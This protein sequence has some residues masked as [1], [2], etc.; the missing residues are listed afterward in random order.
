MAVTAREVIMVFRGQNYLSSTIRQVGRSVGGLSQGQQLAAQR[1]QLQ[2]TRQRMLLFRNAAQAELQSVQ[3]GA[4]RIG[5][6][7][8]IAEQ[9]VAQ[10]RADATLLRNQ[11]QLG[12]ATRAVNSGRPLRG[13]NMVETI[14]QQ[15]A[16]QIQVAAATAAIENQQIAVNKL[17]ADEIRLGEREAQ[18]Q[19]TVLNRTRGIGIY[20]DKLRNLRQ[21]MLQLP[22]DNFQRGA[23]VVEHAGRVIQM[24]GLIAGAAF[25]Y[26][27]D[28]AAKFQTAGTLAA[29]QM[30]THTTNSVAQI[31]RTGAFLSQQLSNF[32]ASGKSVLSAQ[33]AQQ[34]AYAIPSGIPSLRGDSINKAKQTVAIIKELNTVIKANF[35]LVTSDQASSA[36]II[37]VNT[38]NTAVK[39]LPHAFDIIQSAVNRGKVT[40]GEFISG[41]SQTAPAAKG[42]G[43]SLSN[44]ASTLS[45]LSGKLPQYTRVAV[46]YSRALE[47]FQNPKLQQ[48]MKA[49]GAAITDNSGRLLQ[50][51]KIIEQ[52]LKVFPDLATKHGN[53][54]ADLTKAAGTKGFVQARRV[55]TPSLEDV[56]G[57]NEAMKSVPANASGLVNA[58]ATALSKTGAVKWKELTTQLK[59]LVII[60]GE[61]AIP[62][63]QK[64]SKPIEAA[65]N[66]FNKLSPGV[67]NAIGYFGA[68]IAIG[69]LVG[70]TLMAV[71]GGLAYLFASLGKMILFDKWGSSLF[72]FGKNATVAK[73]ALAGL[74][75]EAG[76]ISVGGM[77]SLG[78]PLAIPLLIRYHKQVEEVVNKLGGLGNTLQI[79]FA[80]IAAMKFTRL[81]LGLKSIEL[82]EINAAKSAGKLRLALLG[83]S[84]SSILG[85]LSKFAKGASLFAG[86]EL[87]AIPDIIKQLQGKD[88]F[89]QPS[90]RALGITG[91]AHKLIY[92]INNQFSD[93]MGRDI[94]KPNRIAQQFGFNTANDIIKAFL[95]KKISPKEFN[96]FTKQFFAP[97]F[98][99]QTNI[100]KD[101]AISQSDLN[102]PAKQIDEATKLIKKA[103]LG[104]LTALSKLGK[105]TK[106]THTV[107]KGATLTPVIPP[108]RTVQSWITLIEAAR[109]KMLGSPNDLQAAKHYEQL[110]A[111]LNKQYKDQPNLLAAINDVLG[112]YDTATKKVINSTKTLGVTTQDVLT[113]MTSMYNNFL[114]QETSAF[115]TLFSG[116]FSQS[117]QMQ[118]NLQ[119]GGQLTGPDLV[120]DLKSQLSQFTTFHNQLNELSKRGAP[121]ELITQ[122][123]A[124]GPAALKQ[125]ESLNKL[126]PN[127]LRGYFKL[128]QESQRAI[129]QQT[130]KDLN[131]QLAQYRKYGRNIALQIVAGLRDEN[132]QLTHYLTNLIKRMFPGLPTGA[133]GAGGRPTHHAPGTTHTTH[134]TTYNVT[135]PKSDTAS[136]KA[137]LRH[138]NFVARQKAQR[139]GP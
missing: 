56:A 33:E 62:A 116:P 98:G 9:K 23:Q 76:F 39:D 49:N 105:T 82:A 97:Q 12:R 112:N 21:T 104:Y 106:D 8:A 99:K 128:F 67:K 3:T 66:W 92:G 124:L 115:G 113:S 16:L 43:Y 118:N 60:I 137:Q 78:I 91:A 74:S 58:S 59:Q 1:T 55:L 119:F 88:P 87:P 40:L 80:G 61:G 95:S 133:T 136:V 48:F 100:A 127:A 132:V 41:L 123:E 93:A 44:M 29:T 63:F 25:G 130:M 20:N 129:H 122:L 103:G 83:L 107:V 72:G 110:V 37:L 81:V 102:K 108:A 134:N 14:Q 53:L 45:F 7:K 68:F 26:A 27:A 17:A 73:G 35:G 121:R 5:Q 101:F 6:E 85:F 84:G 47:L 117:P 65:L 120:K 114:S 13:F 86:A 138:A 52:L 42:A 70:G 22:W 135:A 111:A 50:Y 71:V 94:N 51:N 96:E 24:F 109:K 15:K 75:S 36:A 46:G 11:A 10:M 79:A 31:Q 19:Q 139:R 32:L 34:A 38:F 4:R 69:A 125:I 18:L 54:I 90:A 57:L 131:N 28:Q 77:L 30:I 2:V 64:L 89:G 126:P